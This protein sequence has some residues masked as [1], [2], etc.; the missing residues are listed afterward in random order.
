M[1][2]IRRPSHGD[3]L[4]ALLINN[5]LPAAD[6]SRVE[7]AIKKYKEWIERLNSAKGTG[8]ELLR[9]F[10]DALNDYKKSL[11]LELIFDATDD[12]LYRQKG[13]LKLDNTVLEEFMP[14]LFDSRLIPGLNRLKNISCGPHS[15]FA[16][17]SFDSPFISLKAGGV[18]LKLKDQDFSVSKAHHITITDDPR[19]DD[20][21]ESKFFVSHFASEIK[22]NL[23]KTMFQEAS[24]TS[25][26]L[27]RAVPGSRYVLLCEYLDM[28]PINTKLTSIDEVIVL[29][30]A[31]RLASNVRADFSTSEGRVR[32][33]AEYEKFLNQNP[34]HIECFE[35]FLWH[36]NELFP[37]KEE[38]AEDIVLGRGYF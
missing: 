27:K 15:S 31:K 24:Q 26:E 38:D 17:L 8:K 16:G 19:N 30:K 14:Y 21:Y 2:V 25:A 6:R 12:F 9:E 35:R 11:E 29:R 18:F 37:E 33:R 4:K 32:A 13:Q 10:V 22:T 1:E 3:K 7:S 5:K 23:D 20:K 34:L 28:T 36:L